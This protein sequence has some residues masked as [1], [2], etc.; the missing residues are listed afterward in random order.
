MNKI[1]SKQSS[2]LF[3]IVVFFWFAQYVYI[4]YQTT[5]L[6]L[7]G[8]SSNLVGTIIGAYGISQLV[9]RL[10]VGIL[11]DLSSNHKLFIIL[12]SLLA[13]GA[14][15]FRILLPEDIGFLLANI[16]SGMASA[17][18][19]SFMIL[20]MSY[21]SKENQT[22]ATSKIIMANNTGMLLG[23][24]TSTFLYDIVGMMII[25]TLSLVAG[26]IACILALFIQPTKPSSSSPKIRVVELLHVIKDKNLILY[27][28]LAL[29]QQGV[30]M[31]TTM[32]F[33]NQ[34]IQELGA[35]NMI[36]GFSSIIY[37]LSAVS[38]AKLA[39]TE[40][41]ELLTKKQWIYTSFLLLGIYCLCVPLMNSIILVCLLQLIPGIGTGILFSLLTS[42]AMQSIPQHKRST[43]MG[44]F[45]AVYAIGMT[46]FPIISGSVYDHLS[47]KVA[48]FFLA[49]TCFIAFFVSCSY[50]HK[51]EKKLLRKNV[52]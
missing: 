3:I 7:A 46:I 15:L 43:A 36:I 10:P 12:G 13:G 21:Y 39:S 37:M 22:R 47:M 48:Y 25:C 51:E 38:F 41:L 6:L 18:W 52:S 34:V 32:S 23:F 29:V 50:S 20:Y 26:L 5:Y 28:C 35:T 33:T 11:A 1:Q 42:E 17:T 27:S 4:P 8:I 45:Q 16:L 30:Q 19:I 44:F 49:G 40:L 24:V 2:L 14:S 9:L 31:S